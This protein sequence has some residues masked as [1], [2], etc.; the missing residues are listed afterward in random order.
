MQYRNIYYLDISFILYPNEY[1]FICYV[2]FFSIYFIEH[3]QGGIVAAV[4][5]AKVFSVFSFVQFS[6]LW[7]LMNLKGH[8]LLF[9]LCMTGSNTTQFIA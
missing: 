1:K 9:I 5:V 3:S 6:Q 7:K 8:S 2:N 4:N